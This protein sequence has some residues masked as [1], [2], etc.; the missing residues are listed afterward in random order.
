M[1][2]LVPLDSF[3]FEDLEAEGII[4]VTEPVSEGTVKKGG[5]WVNKGKGGTHGEFKTKKAADAQRK[6]MFANGYKGLNEEGGKKVFK[7]TMTGTSRKDEAELGVKGLRV[8]YNISAGSEKE[9]RAIAR[10]FDSGKR[11]V[12]VEELKESKKLQ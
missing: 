9:A 7:V 10:K 3:D 4:E 11:V 2:Y 6:A 8:T 5:K 12:G 1:D